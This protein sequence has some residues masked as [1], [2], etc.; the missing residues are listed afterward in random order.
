MHDS[1]AKLP[2]VSD[3]DVTSSPTAH[4]NNRF[5][6]YLFLIKEF[7]FNSSMI[8]IFE[9]FRNKILSISLKMSEVI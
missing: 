7:D 9:I 4:V 8:V 6:Y 2:F 5:P 1:S 3:I